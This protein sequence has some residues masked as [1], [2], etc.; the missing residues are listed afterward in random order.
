MNSLVILLQ[1]TVTLGAPLILAALGGFASER[2]GV[3]NIALEGKMLTSCAVTAIVALATHNA[4][5]GVVAGIG[6]AVVISLAHW[7]LTQIYQIDHIVSGMAINAFALGATNFLDK[8]FSDPGRGEVPQL[9]TILFY[10]LS[11]ALPILVAW[12]A[13]RTRGGL[14]LRAVGSDPNKAR[15]MG[16]SP[17]R[18]RFLGLLWCGIFCGLSGALIVTNAKYFTDGM[19]S[20]R[21]FIALA[22]LIIGGWRPI[23]TL[24]ACLAFGF[25]Q[26]LQI[27]LQGSH[28]GGFEVPREAWL[29]LPYLATIIA[30]AGFLGKNRA[31]GGL[32][33]P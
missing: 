28:V 31:P 25:L 29:C 4:A 9:P 11:L 7:L 22:A 23:P 10:V 2:G 30:L 1:S 17:L 33:Q 32:G 8:R 5:A 27:V 20:G 13:V 19:T 15:T 6:A 21:G 12:I 24:I 18:V 26:A 16:I 3:I 14:R